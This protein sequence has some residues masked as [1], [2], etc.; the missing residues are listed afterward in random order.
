MSWELIFWSPCG[1]HSCWK[2]VLIPPKWRPIE[3]WLGA[4]DRIPFIFA[5]AEFLSSS[6]WM[7]LPTFLYW[8]RNEC[9]L[10]VQWWNCIYN[11]WFCHFPK[12]IRTLKGNYITISND[13]WTFFGIEQI[14]ENL[15]LIFC[16]EDH[17]SETF[18]ENIVQYSWSTEQI[19]FSTKLDFFDSIKS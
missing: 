6:S 11:F 19:L 14:E 17:C 13:K 5:L 12:L 15:K 2:V 16:I 18:P 3:D 9:L 10:S 1:W 7:I 4:I 8:M